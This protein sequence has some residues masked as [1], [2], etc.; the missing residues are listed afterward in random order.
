MK[1]V[2][3]S[4]LAALIVVAVVGFSGCKDKTLTPFEPEVANST[5]TFQFQVTKAKDVT[6]ILNY[7]WQ[8]NG[9]VANVNQACAITAGEATV[10][11]IDADQQ[12]VYTKDLGANGT[13][14]SSNGSPGQWTIRVKLQNMSGTLNFRVQTP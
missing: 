12:V 8:N 5:G 6:T 11:V 4:V 1:S 2:Y 9:E 13:Y 3:V 10:T 14:P 7:S